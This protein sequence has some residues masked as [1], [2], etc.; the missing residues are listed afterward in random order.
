MSSA[1]HQTAAMPSCLSPEALV[2]ANQRLYA[3]RTDPSRAAARSVVVLTARPQQLQ[4]STAIDCCHTVYWALGGDAGKSA[5]IPERN[6]VPVMQPGSLA[7]LC[8]AIA[9]LIAAAIVAME[10]GLLFPGKVQPCASI[11]SGLLACVFLARAV[12]DFRYVRFF[13]KSVGSKFAYLDTWVFWPLCVL[14]ALSIAD[15]IARAF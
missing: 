10:A 3:F 4:H 6:G 12:G 13:K 9:L 15:A 8:A 5:A 7:S 11:L 2:P 14:L 1:D